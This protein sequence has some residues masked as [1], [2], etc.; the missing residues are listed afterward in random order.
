[1]QNHM[2]HI[3]TG[4]LTFILYTGVRIVPFLAQVQHIYGYVDGT[5]FY[6]PVGHLLSR[7]LDVCL[8]MW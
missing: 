4:V 3:S 8:T 7:H 5:E 6:F 2:I 1:M